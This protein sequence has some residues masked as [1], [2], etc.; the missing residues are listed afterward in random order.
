MERGVLVPD[1]VGW[2]LNRELANVSELIL[3]VLLVKMKP[4]LR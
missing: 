3:A 4:L 2:E 1:H